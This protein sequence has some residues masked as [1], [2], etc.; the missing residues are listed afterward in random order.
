MGSPRPVLA[1]GKAY[2][3]WLMVRCNINGAMRYHKF[4]IG[5]IVGRFARG[6]GG[7]PAQ[8]VRNRPRK[9]ISLQLCSNLRHI[10][11]KHDD[12]VLF[13][14]FIPHMVA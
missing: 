5:L 6:A 8:S 4:V 10:V 12:I 3:A 11:S 2:M 9:P 1:R 14:G 7:F 13:A